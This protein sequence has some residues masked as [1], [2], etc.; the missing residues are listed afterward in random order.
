[1]LLGSRGR[2][3]RQ[4]ARTVAARPQLYLGIVPNVQHQLLQ[5]RVWS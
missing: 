5:N 1:M 3:R 2:S 4:L